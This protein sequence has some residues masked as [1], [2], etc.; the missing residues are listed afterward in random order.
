MI[1]FKIFRHSPKREERESRSRLRLSAKSTSQ[2][3]GLDTPITP[4]PIP[5]ITPPDTR[6]YLVMIVV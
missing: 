1:T 6:I 3:K 2:D 4:F 5:L